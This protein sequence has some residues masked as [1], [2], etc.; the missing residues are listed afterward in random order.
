V[1]LEGDQSWKLGELLVKLF[2]TKIQITKSLK[3]PNINFF[4]SF[5]GQRIIFPETKL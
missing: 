1:D 2:I 3:D 4:L 5:E